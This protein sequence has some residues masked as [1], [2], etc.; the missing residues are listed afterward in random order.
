MLW[1]SVSLATVEAAG[2]APLLALSRTRET[3]SAAAAAVTA[4]A[5]ATDGYGWFHARGNTRFASTPIICDE[6]NCTTRHRV[7]KEQLD[8]W[9]S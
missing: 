9:D 8:A 7:S 3:S 4:A 6:H 1:S 5:V 2:V